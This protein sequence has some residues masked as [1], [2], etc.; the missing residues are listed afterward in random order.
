MKGSSSN[1]S[2][3]VIY[4]SFFL[5]LAGTVRRIC[6]SHL[7]KVPVQ[8]TVPVY[9]SY[10]FSNAIPVN[11]GHLPFGSERKDSFTFSRKAINLL[12]SVDLVLWSSCQK[13]D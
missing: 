5:Q 4:A 2:D 12:G 10:H 11:A 13:Y 6:K 9:R 7:P 8:V 1:T 3:G